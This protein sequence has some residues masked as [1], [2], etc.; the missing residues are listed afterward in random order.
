MEACLN[1]RPLVALSCDDDGLE[2]LTPGHFLIV[3][4]L[5]ALPDPAVSYR[6]VTLLRRWHLCQN[7]IRHFWQR[8]P[9][10]YLAN[11]RKYAKWHKFFSKSIGRRSCHCNEDGMIP[12]TWPLGRVIEVFT[13]KDGIVRVVN[14]KTKNGIFK[15]P[16]H[17]LAVLLPKEQ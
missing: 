11:L 14:V 15:R 3:R 16:V 17:K 7:L 12:T 8:W 5:E 9:K 10:D 4:P 13:G 2:A 6:T 1:S